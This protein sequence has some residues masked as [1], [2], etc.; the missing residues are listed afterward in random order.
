MYN[1]HWDYEKNKYEYMSLS[2]IANTMGYG[3]KVRKG[4]PIRRGLKR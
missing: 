4:R 1:C 3:R 2:E